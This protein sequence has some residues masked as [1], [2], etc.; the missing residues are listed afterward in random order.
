VVNAGMDAPQYFL[1]EDWMAKKDQIFVAMIS[2]GN[3]Y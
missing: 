1:L 3:K 2:N